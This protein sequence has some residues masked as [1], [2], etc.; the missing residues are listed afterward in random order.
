MTATN[1]P[2]TEMVVNSMIVAPE[3][4]QTMRATET[5]EI[6]GLAGDGGDGIAV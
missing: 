3:N 1:E 6:R 5:V 4:D 2:I